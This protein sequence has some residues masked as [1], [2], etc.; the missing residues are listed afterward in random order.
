MIGVS[1]VL[2][3]VPPTGLGVYAWRSSIPA[4]PWAWFV[5]DPRFPAVVAEAKRRGPTWLFRGPE[6]WTLE[7]WRATLAELVAIASRP[8]SGFEGVVVNPEAGWDGASDADFAEFGD[9]LAQAA[10]VTRIGVVTIPSWRGFERVARAAGRMVWWSIELYARTTAPSTFAAHVARWRSVVGRRVVPSLAGFIPATA[11]GREW[12]DPDE[13]GSSY[14]DYLAAVPRAS[15]AIVWEGGVTD[16]MR[17][18]LSERFGPGGLVSRALGLP[19]ALLA[20][21]DTWAGL[22]AVVLALALLV[23]AIRKDIL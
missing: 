19:F 1:T 22:A 8:L 13:D 4:G 20:L 11:M 17:A 2:A 7:T 10:L 12:I 9:A 16:W 21:P 14:R 15:G 6:S 5:V 3:G 23:F 18:A